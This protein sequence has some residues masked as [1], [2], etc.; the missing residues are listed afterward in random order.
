[1]LHLKKWNRKSD[2]KIL[3]NKCI[4]LLSRWPFF[5]A[6]KQFLY[7]IYKRQLMGPF[8]IPL[9]R[10]IS[11]FLYD[12]PFPSPVNYT[13]CGKVWNAI[14]LK[15]SSCCSGEAENF[16]SI[17][18]RRQDTLFPT[19]RITLAKIRSFFSATF[20]MFGTRKLSASFVTCFDWTDDSNTFL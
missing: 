11:H 10:W 9:E 17:K 6:F 8:D 2:R 16:G 15:L 19:W 3:A 18:R 7:F 1:M 4:C 13:Q 12:V 14:T 20:S 5:E